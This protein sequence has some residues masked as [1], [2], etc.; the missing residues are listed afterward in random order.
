MTGDRYIVACNGHALPLAPTSITGQAVA[1]VRFRAWP[2][3]QGFHPTIPPHVPLNFDLIDTWN[4]RS[5]AG[6]R[7]HATHP[8]GRNF[9]ALPVNALE[10]ESRRHARFES[11]AHAPAGTPLR[12]VGV[13][14]DSPLTLDLR[15]VRHG[16]H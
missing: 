16:R 1:A 4:E 13:H 10:A 12:T 7:Y 15:R 8:G 5:V 11:M 14:P 2:G 6:C 9:H 3:G